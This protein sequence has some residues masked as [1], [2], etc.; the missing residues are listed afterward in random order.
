MPLIVFGNDGVEAVTLVRDDTPD[1]RPF[2]GD[3]GSIESEYL[4]GMLPDDLDD[5][6]RQDRLLIESAWKGLIQY[7][8]ATLTEVAHLDQS[9]S[10]INFPVRRPRRWL[11]LD[12]A[13]KEDVSAGSP[14]LLDNLPGRRGARLLQT[15]DQVVQATVETA[16]DAAH[17]GAYLSLDHSVSEQARNRASVSIRL[18]DIYR[19]TDNP[20]QE[21]APALSAG[22]EGWFLFGYGNLSL[23]VLAPGAY[24]AVSTLGRV[25]AVLSHSDGTATWAVS[26]DQVP[27]SSLNEEV[28][29]SLEYFPQEDGTIRATARVGDVQVSSTAEASFR[30]TQVVMLGAD[31]RSQPRAPY[32]GLFSEAARTSFSVAMREVT[33][34]DT[35]LHPELRAIPSLVTSVLGYQ[36]RLVAGI[37]YVVAWDDEAKWSELRMLDTPTTDVW[38]EWAAFDSRLLEKLF[39]EFIGVP[40][41]ATGPDSLETK[42]KLVALLYGLLA[43]PQVGPLTAAI[44]A[45]AGVPVAMEAG[46]VI[47]VDTSD[48]DPCIVVRGFATDRRYKYPAGLKPLVSVGDFVEKFDLLVEHPTV[49]DWTKGKEFVDA[50]RLNTSSRKLFMEAQKFSAVQINIPYGSLGVSRED[51]GS[52]YNLPNQIH[53]YLDKALPLWCGALQVFLTLVKRVEDRFDML[54]SQDWEGVL[55]VLTPLTNARDPRYN[56]SRGFLYDGS[57]LYNEAE[58]EVLKDR[59]SITATTSGAPITVHILGTDVT[60]PPLPASVTI[61]EPV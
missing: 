8:A 20:A 59:L 28:A 57:L 37:D 32:T 18:A 31:T 50:L 61:D 25:A 34:T 21:L 58:Y 26:G 48:V 41:V 60:V 53:D 51:E 55:S 52:P 29:V 54:D 43:G 9:A 27:L 2:E 24:A 44:S 11:H 17:V 33:W 42:N 14:L 16:Q 22:N 36:D 13:R 23:P 45:L 46:P 19:T 6:P 49:L 47:T 5:L 1:F 3:A 35:S 30:A 40:S 56:D 7:A 39:G 10:L 12:L 38:A 15:P 4:W